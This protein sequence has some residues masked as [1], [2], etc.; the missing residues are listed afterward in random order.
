MLNN[1]EQFSSNSDKCLTSIHS[2][3]AL[4]SRFAIRFNIVFSGADC[5][6][7]HW[8]NDIDE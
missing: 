5:L 6:E 8:E 3:D 7:V 4:L 2:N 1:S